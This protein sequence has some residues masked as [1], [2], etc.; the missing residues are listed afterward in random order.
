MAGPVRNYRDA[1]SADAELKRLLHLA[2]LNRGIF[3]ARRELFNPSTVMT[4]ADVDQAVA[5]FKDA[6]LELK[7][8]IEESS[9]HLLA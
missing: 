9:P 8:Y 7:P 1:A 2:L 3:A 6:L 5:A 4:E